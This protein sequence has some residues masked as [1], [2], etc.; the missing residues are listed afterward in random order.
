[1]YVRVIETG[2]TINKEYKPLEGK[3]GFNNFHLESML[4]RA[5]VTQDYTVE[6][7]FLMDSLEMEDKHREKIA[8]RCKSAPEDHILIGH[9]TDT[10][11][12][13]GKYIA[14]KNIDKTIVLFGSMI[15][16]K[17][18]H[19]D[20]LFNMGFAFATVQNLPKG[21][22]IAMNGQVFDVFKVEKNMKEGKFESTPKA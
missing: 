12:E 13:T 16:Y 2:G 21:V 14:S 5:R 6:S 8:Q 19:S 20:A 18:F 9:G 4:Q 10:M 3:L 22:Y 15:P 1:M 7:L 11:V 17:Y